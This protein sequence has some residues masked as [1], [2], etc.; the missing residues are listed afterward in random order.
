MGDLL[1]RLTAVGKISLPST[2]LHFFDLGGQRDIRSIWPRY[3][4]E[5]HAVVFVVDASDQARL[6]ETWEV[7]GGC[8]L[9]RLTTDEVLTSPRLLHLP[10]LLLANKQ[11]K[12]SSLTVSEIREAFE[13]WLRA[14]PRDELAVEPDHDRAERMASLDVMGASA[15]EGWVGCGIADDRTGVREAVNWLYIRVQ[16]S[17]QV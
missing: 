12:A 15:L 13:A 11:D 7:F 3:Y 10:L 5:C 17:R 4:D 16:N 8:G 14:R 6:S 1:L 2:T 9:A